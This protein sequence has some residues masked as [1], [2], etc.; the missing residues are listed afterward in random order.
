MA[1]PEDVQ[2]AA[3]D[4]VVHPKLGVGRIVDIEQRE[5]LAGFSHY[6]V[7]DIISKQLT[8]RVPVRNAARLGMRRV[9]SAPK[10][11]SVFEALRSLPMQLPTSYKERQACIDEKLKTHSPLAVAEAVRDLFWH[12]KMGHLTQADAHLLDRGRE[13]LV[14]EMAAATGSDRS[15]FI[16]RIDSALHAAATPALATPA[17]TPTQLP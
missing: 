10:L 3:G 4:K 17:G 9:M 5:P 1:V 16:A 14:S 11:D 8:V 12:G 13:L 2:F 15:E 7:V 6:Y